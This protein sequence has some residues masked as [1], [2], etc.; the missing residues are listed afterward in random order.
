MSFFTKACRAFVGLAGVGF[1]G[2][3]AAQAQ[4]PIKIGLLLPYSGP[5]ADLGLQ[6]DT[7]VTAYMKQNGDAIGG[8]KI[9][10]LKRDTTGVAP[11]IAKRL[12]QELV[13]RDKVDILTGVVFT[14]NALAIA[15]VATE[16]K[17]PFIIMNA[18]T[19]IITTRSPYIVRVSLTLPQTIM[20]MGTWAAKNG[21]KKVYTLVSD[22]GPGHDVETF[23]KK[24]FTAA[25]G[26]I[27]GEVRVPLK[28][29][30]FAP[31]LQRVKDAKPDAVFSFVPA[32]EQSIAYFKGVVERGFKEAGI[33]ILG[34]ASMTEDGVLES[35]GDAAL[36][37]ITAGNY[38]HDHNSPENAAFIKAFGEVNNKIRPNFFAVG[39]WDGMAAIYAALKAQN[40][41]ADGD[42]V[43]EFL[44]TW[45]TTSPRGPIAID[46]ETRDI[47][48]DVYIRR[49]ERKAGKL[50]NVEF[51]SF[52]MV[53]DPGK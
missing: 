38:S 10:I 20:P 27:V 29:P 47:V 32:G 4:E 15:P 22:Y 6:M 35:I 40:G 9:E 25:G 51:E 21:I 7:A 8:R 24:Y 28:N 3:G 33:K 48:Q 19:S 12:A 2:L 45:K 49:V 5:F 39:A 17:K 36:G 43:V 26:E 42:K 31:Y 16:A 1:L 53:K 30:E 50:V 23:F 34:E 13:V 11:E 46:A 37:T 52:P 41:Q 14:P 44:K 18:A